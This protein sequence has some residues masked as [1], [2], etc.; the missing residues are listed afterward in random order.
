MPASPILEYGLKYSPPATKRRPALKAGESSDPLRVRVEQLLDTIEHEQAEAS[1]LAG[2]RDKDRKLFERLE[3]IRFEFAD[4]D[5]SSFG[6]LDQ[7][8][9]AKTDAAYLTAFANSS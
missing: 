6:F 9:A 5:S 1:R 3:A 7:N 4:K 8:T 2:E